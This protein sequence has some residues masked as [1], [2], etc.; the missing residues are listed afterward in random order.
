MEAMEGVLCHPSVG[1]KNIPAHSRRVVL[2][3]QADTPE[4][5]DKA[6]ELTR[7]LLRTYHAVVIASLRGRNP[8]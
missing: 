1:L 8:V 2:L 6:C 5:F 4:L 7:R 3:N